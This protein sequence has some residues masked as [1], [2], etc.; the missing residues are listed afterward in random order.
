MWSAKHLEVHCKNFIR[1]SESDDAHFL[2]QLMNMTLCHDQAMKCANTKVHVYSDSV[3]CMGRIHQA[4][5][6][7]TKRKEQFHYFQ[8]SNEYT[9]LSG[10]DDGEPIEFEWHLFPGF[11]SFE[12]LRRTKQDLNVPRINSDQFEERI[13]TLSGQRKEVLMYLEIQKVSGYAKEFPR[14]H[15]SFFGTG[16]EENGHLKL[17][18][19]RK[20]RPASQSDDWCIRTEWAS[21]VSRHKCGR[22]GILKQKQGRK[23][24]HFTTGFRKWTLS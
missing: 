22:R 2:S 18:T 11:T 24:I 17:H 12:I 4:S 21:R 23:T 9:E 3:L 1:N 13:T 16:D 14:G 15:W 20:M 7:N 8:Q 5:E 6:A 19:W 10:I